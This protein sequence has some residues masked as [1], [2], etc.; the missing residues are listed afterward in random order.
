MSW[1]ALGKTF[2]FYAFFFLV[3]IVLIWLTENHLTL[4]LVLLSAICLV[5]LPTT[6]YQVYKSYAEYDE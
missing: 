5:L 6:I 3:A 1:K 2:L 4:S